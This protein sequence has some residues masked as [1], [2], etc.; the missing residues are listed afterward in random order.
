MSIGNYTSFVTVF[1]PALL[2]LAASDLPLHGKVDLMWRLVHH[3]RVAEGYLSRT[4]YGRQTL[5]DFALE[6]SDNEQ[7]LTRTIARVAAFD[8]YI[9]HFSHHAI[10]ALALWPPEPYYLDLGHGPYGNGQFHQKRRISDCERLQLCRTAA[11]HRRNVHH[12]DFNQGENAGKPQQQQ[13]EPR[14]RDD[15]NF[16][17]DSSLA[18]IVLLSFRGTSSLSTDARPINGQ[19]TPEDVEPVETPVGQLSKMILLRFQRELHDKKRKNT[20]SSHFA[21]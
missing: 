10:G 21:A 14:K 2:R 3:P 4:S 8:L 5:R 1:K 13:I 19:L 18:S 7:L 6:V 12:A 15:F 20:K 16:F 17:R 11:R 9:R